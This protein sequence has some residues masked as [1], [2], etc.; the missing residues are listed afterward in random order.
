MVSCYF[1][2]SEWGKNSSRVSSILKGAMERVRGAVGLPFY[3]NP[4]GAYAASGHSPNSYHK[5]GM[6]VDGRFSPGKN[7]R[8]ELE[9]ILTVSEINGIGFYPHWS[10]RAG[11]HLDIREAP[12]VYW[13]ET[14]K[15]GKYS[16]FDSLDAFKIALDAYKQ[17]PPVGN[18]DDF[19]LAYEAVMD[20]EGRTLSTTPGD[21]GGETYRG[22]S[23]KEH[24]SLDLWAF[25]DAAKTRPNFPACLEADSSLQSQVKAFYK[26]VFWDA[27]GCGEMDY[28][29]AL[30][31]F[32]FGVNSGTRTASKSLQRVLN[33]MNKGASLWPD[34]TP[35]G[36]FGQKETLP[37]I[38]AFV[39]KY[40]WAKLAKFL[41]M[42]QA[43]HFFDLLE[44]DQS[45]E[46][47]AFG[48]LE[49]RC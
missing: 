23:R 25:I 17:E 5:K 30:E 3:I 31:V 4:N 32:D 39:A 12:K 6:A 29:L 28:T 19:N 22:I 2:E 42:F 24:P 47:F 44:K 48:W 49:N 41:N 16:Y 27:M 8:Q 45:Q 37:A 7:P 15:A 34:I 43:K 38:N 40:G 18:D 14:G 9:G 26:V 10:P 35:D 1:K 33:V 46:T 11:W 20:V 13:I 36:R 21:R